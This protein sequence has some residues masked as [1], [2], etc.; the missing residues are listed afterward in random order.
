MSMGTRV[1]GL[2]LRAVDC[3]INFPAETAIH[4]YEKTHT[5]VPLVPLASGYVW[6]DR[7]IINFETGDL[8]SRRWTVESTERREFTIVFRRNER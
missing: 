5:A 2:V 1:R 3:R 8:A 4:T 6:L 7:F